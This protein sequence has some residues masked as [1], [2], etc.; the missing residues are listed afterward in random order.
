MPATTT[1]MAQK[2]NVQTLSVFFCANTV[3]HSL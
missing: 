1:I 3:S 2:A